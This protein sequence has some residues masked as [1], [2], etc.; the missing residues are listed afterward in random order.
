[1]SVQ[2]SRGPPSLY[3]TGSGSG[4]LFGSPPVRYPKPPPP[5]LTSVRCAGISYVEH[6]TMFSTRTETHLTRWDL[7]R[8]FDGSHAHRAGPMR[9]FS[10]RV[11]EKSSEVRNV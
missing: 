3:P 2:F 1:M 11:E 7:A 8:V 9:V 5:H 6:G 10:N 4:F